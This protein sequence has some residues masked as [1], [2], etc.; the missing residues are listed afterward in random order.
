MCVCTRCVCVRVCVA[1]GGG[2]GGGVGVVVADAAAIVV[3][4]GFNDVVVFFCLSVCLLV[5]F[6]LLFSQHSLRPHCTE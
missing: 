5:W 1:V 6:L 2:G 3:V 4:V